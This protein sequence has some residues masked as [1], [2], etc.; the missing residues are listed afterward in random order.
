MLI[1]YLWLVV[2]FLLLLKGAYMLVDSAAKLAKDWGVPPLL[3]GMTFVAFG[4]SLPELA[5]SLSSIFTGNLEFPA[6]VVIGSNI[7]NLGFVLGAASFITPL[8]L[9]RT[10]LRRELLFLFVGGGL[11]FLLPYNLLSDGMTYTL[12]WYDG[13]ILLVTFAIFIHYAI[14]H[15]IFDARIKKL[16]SSL[17]KRDAVSTRHFINLLAGIFGVVV[18]SWLAVRYTAQIA[19]SYAVD[20][21]VMGL[22]IMAIGV[23]LPELVTAITAGLRGKKEIAVGMLIGSCIFN[24]LWVLGVSSL[25]A[26]IPFSPFLFFE[27]GVMLLFAFFLYIFVFLQRRLSSFEGFIMIGAYVI[28]IISLF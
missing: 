22:S 12:N 18:G 28:F 2:G 25:F 13:L 19:S 16:Q 4:T 10:E 21:S 1:S 17:T 27:L 11:L 6:S 15:A 26:A 8:Y 5:L 7:F 24:V 20:P 23:S 3:L 9:S 14:R